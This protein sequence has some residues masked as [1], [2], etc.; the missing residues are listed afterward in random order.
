MWDD[1]GFG[2][3]W[4]QKSLDTVNPACF[5]MTMTSGT[6]FLPTRTIVLTSPNTSISSSTGI[7]EASFEPACPS[8][9]PVTYVL[10]GGG[11]PLPIL[12]T[13]REVWRAWVTGS[14]GSFRASMF[15][16]LYSISIC[17]CTVWF[18]LLASYASRKKR[19]IL[20]K[21]SLILSAVYCSVIFGLTIQNI[22]SQYY[23]GYLCTVKLADVFSRQS[24]VGICLGF[25]VILLFSCIQTTMGLFPRAKEK[26]L[27]LAIGGTIVATSQILWGISIFLSSDDSVLPAF[28]YLLQIA[29]AI[30]YACCVIY[31]TVNK[32]QA[33]LCKSLLP[34]TLLTLVVILIPIVLFIVDVNGWWIINW[35]DSVS[36]VSTLLSVITVWEWFQYVEEKFNQLEQSKVLGYQIFDDVYELSSLPDSDQSANGDQSSLKDGQCANERTNTFSQLMKTP[37]PSPEFFKN[38]PVFLTLTQPI[39]WFS[40]RVTTYFVTPSSTPQYDPEREM[41]KLEMKRAE[42]REQMAAERH[43]HPIRKSKARQSCDMH[44][45][46][47]LVEANSSSDQQTSPEPRSSRHE[48]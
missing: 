42:Q 47:R 3:V 20:L 11:F 2:Y 12:N 34:F 39:L 22:K 21:L 43:F 5:P 16:L 33:T 41:I 25:N 40:E 6:I 13:D 8:G 9:S 18:L 23:T 38:H 36:W 1:M 29:Q 48:T 14:D 46:E 28:V 27:V 4:R 24:I 17:M 15:P 19:P 37:T 45:I 26:T 44:E 31:Y 30:L 32:R 10:K 35:V 7:S